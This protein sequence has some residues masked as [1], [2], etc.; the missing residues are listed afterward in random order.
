MKEE[1]TTIITEIQ[2]IMRK[3]LLYA[4]KS[5][6]LEEIEKFL[7]IFNLL[8]LNQKEIEQTDH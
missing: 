7:K 4:N 3:L 1:I 2:K 6:N 5:N 8:C